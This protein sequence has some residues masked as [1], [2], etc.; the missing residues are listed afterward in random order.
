MTDAAAHSQQVVLVVEDEILVRMII[1]D[2]LRS[3]GYR[4]IEAVSADEAMI[5][6]QHRELEVDVVFSD[7]EMPGSMD[8]FELSRWLR[9]NRPT[10]DVILAG[11][12]ARATDA[13]AELCDSGPIPKPYEPQLAAD[14]IRQLMALRSARKKKV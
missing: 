1:A 5:I 14:R 8:G 9:A 2:Y 12:V 4:V 3:C 7:V 11:S 10:V 6:L 13:A